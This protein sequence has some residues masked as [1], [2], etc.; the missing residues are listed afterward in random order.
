MQK[1][2]LKRSPAK[3]SL[4][5]SSPFH[6]VWE[7]TS[8]RGRRPPPWGICCSR[9]MAKNQE[10]QFSHSP[11]HKNPVKHCFV[12]SSKPMYGNARKFTMWSE[13]PGKP[14]P[15]KWSMPVIST[16]LNLR[17]NHIRCQ[18]Y[19]LRY[20]FLSTHINIHTST[21]MSSR[22]CWTCKPNQIWC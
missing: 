5:I 16:L 13:D 17:S 3:G 18:R 9:W 14:E 8:G 11:S 22:R 7:G 1:R 6:W 12:E 21:Y 10:N 15:V 2:T 20:S 19:F 4:Y